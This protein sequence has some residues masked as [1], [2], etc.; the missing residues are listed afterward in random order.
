MFNLINTRSGGSNG[1]P[2]RFNR[3]G[4]ATFT[5]S[6][7]AI[8]GMMYQMHTN[9]AEQ[10]GLENAHHT[11]LYSG[12]RRGLNGGNLMGSGIL[13]KIG[14]FAKKA[15]LKIANYFTSGT[16]QSHFKTA[17][18]IGSFAERLKSPEARSRLVNTLGMVEPIIDRIAKS[19][20]ITFSDM[21]QVG[22]NLWRGQ[23]DQRTAE[24]NNYYTDNFED[25]VEHQ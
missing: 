21:A 5:N 13:Q 4:L 16:A 17:Q 24:R 7:P 8:G 3:G 14:K 22:Q 6:H 10:N 23:P 20:R 19:E 15:L 25:A 2:Y 11:M 9:G 18:K 12:I 1:P